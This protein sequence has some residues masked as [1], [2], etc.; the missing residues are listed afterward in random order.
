MVE[1]EISNNFSIGFIGRVMF[2]FAMLFLF[3]KYSEQQFLDVF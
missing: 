1:F 2:M 3:K